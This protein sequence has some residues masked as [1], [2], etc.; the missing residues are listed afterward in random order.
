[1]VSR[2][3]GSLRL[4][5]LVLRVRYL[6]SFNNIGLTTRFLKASSEKSGKPLSH[7]RFRQLENAVEVPSRHNTVPCKIVTGNLSVLIETGQ[8]VVVYKPPSVV[9]HHS[10]WTGSREI[11]FPM[12]QR[13]RQ[14]FGGRRVN[15]I[16]R[17][18]RGASGCLLLTFSNDRIV[19]NEAKPSNDVKCMDGRDFVSPTSASSNINIT[20]ELNTT[21]VLIN[22][23]ASSRSPK[24]YIALVR[25][26]GI[27][28]G[29]DLKKNGWFLIERPIKNERGI[30]KNASTWFRFIASS[31]NESCVDGQIVSQ[32]RACIVLARPVTGRWHQIRRHLN[33][34]SHPILGDSVH[35]NT[36]T[37]REWRSQ[38]G[39]LTERICLHLAQIKIQPV[40]SVC[41]DGI[42]VN[43]DLATDMML[44]LEQ[45]LPYALEA[46]EPILL[47]EGI[48]LKG[49][50]ARN[51]R[52]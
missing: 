23:M 42:V 14:A 52:F 10:S 30:L 20:R 2:T 13:V 50:E 45:H 5:F 26:S 28:H 29:R 31:Q 35:G 15:L 39:M 47:A 22:A 25:G 40:K 37:N 33:G 17:L 9:C 27:L 32:P 19:D 46:A 38:R 3:I 49:N 48:Q 18:D 44:L 24:T 11:D 1:M 41:P 36:K 6:C 34:L 43:C 21:T 12:L 4:I 51:L 16:H 8:Y 7:K